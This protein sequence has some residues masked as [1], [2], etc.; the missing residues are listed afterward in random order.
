MKVK[1]FPKE[2]ENLNLKP[3]FT[4]DLSLL[5]FTAYSDGF[6]R[7]A[8]EQNARPLTVHGQALRTRRS[9]LSSDPGLLM[10]VLGNP[11]GTEEPA[12]TSCTLSELKHGPLLI[13]SFFYEI[14]QL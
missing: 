14:S 10:D 5:V 3:V 8:A 6:I 4:P 7:R 1:A 13:A 12:L 2:R 11:G 9:R